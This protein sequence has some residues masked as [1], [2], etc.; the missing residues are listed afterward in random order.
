MVKSVIINDDWKGEIANIA[1][2]FNNFAKKGSLRMASFI[3]D[4]LFDI[5]SDD[6]DPNQYDA[7]QL[8][9]RIRAVNPKLL[10]PYISTLVDA[11]LGKY[12]TESGAY[13][14]PDLAQFPMRNNYMDDIIIY[15]DEKEEEEEEISLE[16]EKHTET[17]KIVEEFHKDASETDP[18]EEQADQSDEDEENGGELLSWDL[19][20]LIQFNIVKNIKPITYDEVD[21]PTKKCTCADGKFEK[22]EEGI[23]ACKECMAPYHQNCIKIV[24]ILEGQCRICDN[25]FLVGRDERKESVS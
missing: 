8:L 15:D 18:P 22:G 5:L 13:I 12:Y 6:K 17:D 3:I 10:S 4:K 21:T 11:K 25:S 19:M 14:T 1:L 9:H 20:Q 7:A 16:E 23:W 24:A 2:K